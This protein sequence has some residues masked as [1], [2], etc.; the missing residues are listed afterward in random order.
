MRSKT[1]KKKSKKSE[2]HETKNKQYYGNFHG[3]LKLI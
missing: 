3:S 1:R 2:L